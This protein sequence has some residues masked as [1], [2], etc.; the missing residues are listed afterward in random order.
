MLCLLN[1]WCKDSKNSRKQFQLKNQAKTMHKKSNN[2]NNTTMW[3]FLICRSNNNKKLSTLWHISS[4]TWIKDIFSQNTPIKKVQ[5]TMTWR[6]TKLM[7]LCWNNCK[8]AKAF[9]AKGWSSTQCS[10]SSKP[11]WRSSITK[12]LHFWAVFSSN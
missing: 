10:S 1:S 4:K 3:Y 12:W 11:E 7:I 8:D 9:S 2:N 6:R 5:N